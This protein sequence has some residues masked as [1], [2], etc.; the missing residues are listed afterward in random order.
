MMNDHNHWI[1]GNQ[2]APANGQYFDVL[3]PIDDSLFARAACGSDTDIHC[4]VEAADAC[5]R[6]YRH[7]LPKER[8]AWL[9]QTAELLQQQADD[10]QSLDAE[11]IFDFREESDGVDGL[12]KIDEKHKTDFR[13]SIDLNKK[14]SKAYSPKK[15]TFDNYVVDSNG[16]VRGIIPGTLRV[17][18][19]AQEL[20]KVL[21]EIEAEVE[22]EDQ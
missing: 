2:V 12:K 21:K 10:F 16:I 11:L 22:V 4:A 1:G 7:S 18:A 19:T 9:I 17:R 15:M 5:F 8:E 13:L 3:N 20:I 14:S 6:D